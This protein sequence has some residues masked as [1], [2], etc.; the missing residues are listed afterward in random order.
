MLSATDRQIWDEAVAQSAVL[1]TK[2]RDFSV[3]RA[4]RTD[5]PTIVWIRIGNT[6]NRELVRQIRQALPEIVE[7]IKRGEAVIELAKW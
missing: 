5:G 4:A 2:D 6:G 3:Q 1:V 7:A